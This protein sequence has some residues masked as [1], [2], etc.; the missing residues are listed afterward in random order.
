V[1]SGRIVDDGSTPNASS[2]RKGVAPAAYLRIE[3]EDGSEGLTVGHQPPTNQSA[4]RAVLVSEI[5]YGGF[6]RCPICLDPTVTSREHVPQSSLGGQVRTSTCQR[7]N[8]LLGT[9]VEADLT[10]WCFNTWRN[11]RVDNPEVLGKRRIPALHYRQDETGKFALVATGPVE[12]AVSDM[13]AAGL[14]RL[15]VRP[16][17]PRRYRLAALK[18]SYLAACLQLGEIPNTA[19]AHR[20]RSDLVAARDATAFEL[21]PDSAAAAA[22]GLGRSFKP[23]NG[24]PLALLAMPASEPG[25]RPEPWI[26]LAGTM[27]VQWPFT[28]LQP[29]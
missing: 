24:P 23:P 7:C 21:L 1:W 12:P 13:L 22:L 28:E 26:S 16:P 3:A 6:L 20:I 19:E 29:W 10:D 11:V 15:E 14:I 4:D 27:A 25:G 8:N 9:R 2:R 17:Q 18:H 5:S